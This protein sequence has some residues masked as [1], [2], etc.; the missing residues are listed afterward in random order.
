MEFAPNIHLIPR[1]M[2][3]VIAVGKTARYAKPRNVCV[4]IARQ[5]TAS[6][7]GTASSPSTRLPKTR[8]QNV[9]VKADSPRCNH[10]ANGA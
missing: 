7:A 9:V 6:S 10:L 3:K 8:T 5:S 2:A 4:G 1:T